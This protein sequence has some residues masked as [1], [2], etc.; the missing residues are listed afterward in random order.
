MTPRPSP[1]TA[2]V[3]PSSPA[4][5]L[6]ALA[7]VLTQVL[8]PGGAPSA[9]SLAV[10]SA[11]AQVLQAAA[12]VLPAVL[13][14]TQLRQPGLLPGGYD[15][16]VHRACRTRFPQPPSPSLSQGDSPGGAWWL[17]PSRTQVEVS[18]QRGGWRLIHAT[19]TWDQPPVPGPS[20]VQQTGRLEVGNQL[21]QRLD[22]P[23]PRPPGRQVRQAC[24]PQDPARSPSFSPGA[25]AFTLE[26]QQ[27]AQWARASGDANALHTRPGLAHHLGLD[28]GER[29]VVAHGLLLAAL[30]LCQAPL[31][32]DTL[33]LRF[34]RP[35]ALSPQVPASLGVGPTGAVRAAGLVLLE[36]R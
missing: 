17:W 8:A 33:D 6:E 24:Q 26:V 16:L 31:T 34:R 4:L 25:G 11:Q 35:L 36:R 15:G 29:E 5:V 28:A 10:A 9:A 14:L 30:S 21:A 20:K 1:P 22:P 13:S 32:G 23:A 12:T 27:V 7:E 18:G 2:Q 19:T 3:E